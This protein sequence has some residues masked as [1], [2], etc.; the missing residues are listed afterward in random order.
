MLLIMAAGLG[1]QQRCALQGGSGS[2]P[3]AVASRR[4]SGG[5]RR[6]WPSG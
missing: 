6:S 1:Q 3:T 2:V 5:S 4:T